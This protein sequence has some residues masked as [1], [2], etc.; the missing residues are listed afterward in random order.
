MMLALFGACCAVAAQEWKPQAWPV[1]KTYDADHL[2]RIALPVGGIGT[3]TV[4]LGGRGE[5]RDWEIMNVPAKNYSTVLTCIAAIRERHDGAK[6]NP[7]SEPECGH[8]YARA[9]A[10][11]SAIV[12]LADFQYSGVDKT[13]GVTARP[14]RYFWSNGYSWG[15]VHVSEKDVAIEVLSGT[16]QLKALKVGTKKNVT[17]NDFNLSEGERKVVEL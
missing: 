17:L 12:A 13:M 11:W 10:S 2:Y 16:L 3:G 5:L 4:S 15:T 14:G 6:R 9:M 8:H 1:L 7:F